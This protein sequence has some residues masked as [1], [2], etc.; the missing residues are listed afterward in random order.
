MPKVFISFNYND[1]ASKKVVDNWVK[2]GLGEDISFSSVDGHD[3]LSDGTVKLKKV[4]REK[5]NASQVML[6]LVGK[7]SH[8]RPWV[9][10]EVHHGKSQKKTVIWTQLPNTN[11]AAPKEISKLKDVPFSMNL[12][13]DAIR[14]KFN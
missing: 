8:N 3:I 9:D 10:Y 14:G 13:Q 1:G 6:V 12:I 11:G 4:L 2:Q 5:I 7:D